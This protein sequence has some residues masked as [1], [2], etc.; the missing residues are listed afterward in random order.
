[1]ERDEIFDLLEMDYPEDFEYFEQFADLIELAEE[2][3][4]ADFHELL[5][6][7]ET[8][9]LGEFVETYMEELLEALPDDAEEAFI[10]LSAVQQMLELLAENEDDRANFAKELYR[11]RNWFHSTGPV[12]IDGEPASPM[13]ALFGTRA[14]K[15]TGEA[16]LYDFSGIADYEIERL[17]MDIGTFE[18]IDLTESNDTE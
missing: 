6:E 13:D 5:S 1:M 11:F 3:S 8:E 15:F 9:L 16:H 7:V 17:S 12:L 4:F 2:I 10:K 14:D 18:E